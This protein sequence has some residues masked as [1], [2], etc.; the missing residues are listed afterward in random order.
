MQDVAD[1]KTAY[2]KEHPSQPQTWLCLECCYALGIDP[3]AKPKKTKPKPA[4]AREVRGKITH[5]EERRGV[6]PLGEMCIEVS[7]VVFGC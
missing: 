3:F 4:V 2:T 7:Q 5:Y 1:R 6:N